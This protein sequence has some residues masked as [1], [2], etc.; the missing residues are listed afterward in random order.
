MYQNIIFIGGIHGV[1]KGTAC[2]KIQQSL[3][4]EHLSASDILKWSE[5]SPDRSNKLV[6]DISDTQDRLIKGLQKT[7]DPNKKYI[8]DGHFCLFDSNG[9]VNPVPLDTFLE[10]SPILVSVITCDPVIIAKRLKDRD[11]RKYNISTIVEMQNT[12]IEHAQLIADRLKV[13]F[14]ELSNDISILTNK[15]KSL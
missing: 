9:K 10:I 15:I 4:V 14:I 13:S 11:G 8:L 3:F 12:E 2:A 1:G 7:V 5:V 6:K